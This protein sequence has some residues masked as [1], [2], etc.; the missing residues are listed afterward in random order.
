MSTW[1]GS[2]LETHHLASLRLLADKGKWPQGFPDGSVIKSLPASA[3]DMGLVPGLGRSHTPQ[4][5]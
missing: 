3:G 4:S 5:N 1:S 2:S